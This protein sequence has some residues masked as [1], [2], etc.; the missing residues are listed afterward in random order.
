MCIMEKS[1][2][3]INKTNLTVMIGGYKDE[4]SYDVL[5]MDVALTLLDRPWLY[6][7]NVSH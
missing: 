2:F 6:G 7:L 1:I 3:N 5:S 4:I